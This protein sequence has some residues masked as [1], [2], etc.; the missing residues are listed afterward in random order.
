MEIEKVPFSVPRRTWGYHRAFYFQASVVY[1]LDD[2]EWREPDD[3]L[4]KIAK[5]YRG[6][7]VGA[8]TGFGERDMDFAFFTHIEMLAFIQ[9]AVALFPKLRVHRTT[10]EGP[11][12]STEI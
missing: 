1:S 12:S 6:Y 5:Q 3:A 10:F 9:D 2:Y 11:I 7:K 4:E 8:G